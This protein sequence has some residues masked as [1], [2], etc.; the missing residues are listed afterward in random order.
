MM[1]RRAPYVSPSFGSVVK[2]GNGTSVL[3]AKTPGTLTSKAPSM[4]R[5][6]LEHVIR[7]AAEVTN[8]YELLR[9]GYVSPDAVID[10]VALMLL[11]TDGKK[12]MRARIRRWAKLLEDRDSGSAG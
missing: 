7:A 2:I 10:L 11:G 3:A 4:N 8:E 12:A 9:H 6:E 5:K 1:A